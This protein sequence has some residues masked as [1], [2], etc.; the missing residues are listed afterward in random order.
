MGSD[1]MTGSDPGSDWTGTARDAARELEALRGL[2]DR[3][4]D[5][6]TKAFARGIAQGQ[7]FDTILQGVGRSLV[8]MGLRSAFAPL[9]ALVGQAFG[10]LTQGLLG[11]AGITPFAQAA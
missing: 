8:E 11:A 2:A 1:E 4:G 7:E 3:F 6:L 9:Q 5:S 10:G